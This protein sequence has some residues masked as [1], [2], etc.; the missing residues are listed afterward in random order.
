MERTKK[1]T[2]KSLQFGRKKE[3]FSNN[4]TSTQAR[5]DSVHIYFR[6]NLAKTDTALRSFLI[7][8]II[9]QVATTMKTQW[10]F[11]N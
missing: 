7:V 11:F 3:Y 1:E 9:F 4:R 2:L 5:V 8:P 10:F 6:G